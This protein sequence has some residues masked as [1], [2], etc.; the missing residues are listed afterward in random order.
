M[1]KDFLN[2]LDRAENV[3]ERIRQQLQEPFDMP[4]QYNPGGGTVAIDALSWN[5]VTSSMATNF[6]I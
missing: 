1:V 2:D 4:V 3:T 6:A 5:D